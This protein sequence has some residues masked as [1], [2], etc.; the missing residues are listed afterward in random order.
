MR[1]YIIFD[2]KKYSTTHNNWVP[3]TVHPGRVR[4]TPDSGLDVTYAPNS[5]LEFQGEIRP[6]GGVAPDGWGTLDDFNTSLAKHQILGFED[7]FGNVYEAACLGPLEPRSM[8]PVYDQ[9]L[10][11]Y[12]V[13]VR[14]HIST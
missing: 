4:R 13:N 9:L 11:Q 3:K 6:Y 2:S 12:L 1:N 10:N 5:Y 7:H 8:S 14:F